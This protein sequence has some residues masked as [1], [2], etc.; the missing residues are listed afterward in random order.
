MKLAKII[1]MAWIC[2]AV[3]IPNQDVI[4]NQKV[5]VRYQETSIAEI[6][7]DLQQQYGIRFSFINN[8]IPDD[9][10]VSVDLENQPLYVAL[11]EVFKNTSL[12]YQVIS[13]Q[14]IVKKGL[15]K[16]KKE[17][18]VP[19]AKNKPAT[20]PS[21]SG[22]VPA[23]AMRAKDTADE[24][25]ASKPSDIAAQS[26]ATV[27]M[28]GDAVAIQPIPRQK[29]FPDTIQPWQEALPDVQPESPVQ[30]AQPRE[31]ATKSQRENPGLQEKMKESG[32]KLRIGLNN[33]FQKLPGE[34]E[35]DYERKTFHL[36]II[37]PLSTNG[38]DAGRYVNELSFHWMVGY[39]AGLDGVEFS[40]FGSI[41]NDFVHG[42]QGAGFF[43]LVRNEVEGVQLAGFMNLNGGY[44][45]GAQFSGFLNTTAGD[46][47]GVQGSGFLNIASGYTEGAQLS[48]FMNIA[49]ADADVFQASGF[50]NITAGDMQGAQMSGFL[51]YSGDVNVQLSGFANV[52]SGNVKGLQASGFVNVADNVQGVQLGILNLA[53]SVSGVPIGLLSVV[54][55][56]GF[57]QL[58][59][60]GGATMQA[61]AAFKIGVD[62]FYNIFAIGS[63][64]A[65]EDFRW[66]LGYGAGTQIGLSSRDF[67]NVELISYQI[68]EDNDRWYTLDELNLLNTFRLAY[69]HQFS[70]HFSLFV[71]PTFNVM[72]S[73]RQESSD[74][75]IGSGIAPW[76]VFDETYDN[77]TNVQMWP[78]FHAGI[79]F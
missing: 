3:Y 66:G 61:N 13:G 42:V 79:R 41:E 74:G 72:V 40:G 44:M 77:R 67:L 25:G 9:I 46:L 60:W 75:S 16:A 69:A 12:G 28:A 48:G 68:R 78:G 30:E 43:N 70:E 47:N 31:Q 27:S 45:Q 1:S 38:A 14:V 15:Q 7:T 35:D 18:T 29:E 19:P 36:G 71:A 23:E 8:E 65:A 76:T 63:Q 50:A 10:R 32:R 2:L 54:R 62:K 26:T 4:L 24:A 57:R 52:A 56:N 21:Q 53:D 39:A 34:D 22:T 37:Y 51:N 58:E 33:L 55:K 11:D 5:S 49:G 20:E 6:L 17:K 73:N 59:V 64:F